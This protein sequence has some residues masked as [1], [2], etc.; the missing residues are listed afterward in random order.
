MSDRRAKLEAALEIAR[1]VRNPYLEANL[2][3]AL[4]E[5]RKSEQG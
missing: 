5:L 2:K 1:R 4:E 3:A